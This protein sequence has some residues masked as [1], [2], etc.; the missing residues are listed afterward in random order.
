MTPVIKTKVAKLI[1]TYN[2][3]QKFPITIISLLD[4]LKLKLVSPAIS[5]FSHKLSYECNLT[6][7]ES[8]MILPISY[9]QKTKQNYF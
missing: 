4:K 9:L 5:L 8:K 2:S 3:D 7:Y 6:Y 1:Y